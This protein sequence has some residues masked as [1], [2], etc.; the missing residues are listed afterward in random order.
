[1]SFFAMQTLERNPF[2]HHKLSLLGNAI[3]L[4]LVKESLLLIQVKVL[5]MRTIIQ[6][7][8]RLCVLPFIVFQ[9]WS[10]RR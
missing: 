3:S 7:E 8:S 2:D 6:C 5:G 4:A 10:K 1:M 9:V